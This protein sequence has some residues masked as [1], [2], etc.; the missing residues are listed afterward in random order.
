MSDAQRVS[1]VGTVLVMA[2]ATVGTLQILVLN[3]LAAV[4]G[5]GLGGIYREVAKAGE[6]MVPAAVALIMLVGPAVAI[7]WLVQ[8][9]R[10]PGIRAR[11]RGVRYAVLLALGTPAYFFASFGPGMSLADTFAIS[12]ADY[13]PWAIPLYVT[14]GAAILVIIL[15]VTLK[16]PG[17]PTFPR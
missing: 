4:P 15:L 13:S 7:F 16:R 8:A 17:A 1:I 10:R 9:G 5:L 14:S 6:T 2:F 11:D 3:P 12:G